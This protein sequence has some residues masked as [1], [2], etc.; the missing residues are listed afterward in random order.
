VC[1]TTRRVQRRGV[2]PP[3]QRKSLRR[4]AYSLCRRHSDAARRPCA[5]LHSRVLKGPVG[6]GGGVGMGHSLR[7]GRAALPRGT[8]LRG[9]GA[10]RFR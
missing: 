9:R 10:V 7:H 5:R 4:M 1:A 3:A 2:Q 6:L 8:V